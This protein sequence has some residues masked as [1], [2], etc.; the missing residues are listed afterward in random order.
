[1]GFLMPKMSMPAIPP[2]PEPVK[3]V[4]YDDSAQK[5][6]TKAAL[7]ALQRK[8]VGAQNTILTSYQGLNDN[9]LTVDKKTLLGA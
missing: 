8:Q 3:P 1:M 7:D 2:V 6:S 9:S 4:A 5:A